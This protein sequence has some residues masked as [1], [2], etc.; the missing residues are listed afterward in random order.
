MTLLGKENQ[1]VILSLQL[2]SAIGLNTLNI[3]H[4]PCDFYL[5]KAVEMINKHAC[6]CSPHWQYQ[7]DMHAIVKSI[8]W[9]LPEHGLSVPTAPWVL[10]SVK[11]EAL[12]RL[13]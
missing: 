5:S 9:V 2:Y 8:Y 1:T 4:R 6:L 10:F 7:V 11:K 12:Q 13:C 3:I